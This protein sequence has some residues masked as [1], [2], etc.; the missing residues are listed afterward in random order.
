[1]GDDEIPVY[2]SH[3]VARLMNQDDEMVD[4]CVCQ[5]WQLD[6]GRIEAGKVPADLPDKMD[7]CPHRYYG[8]PVMKPVYNALED[9][10]RGLEP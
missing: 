8:K 6:T 7:E 9:L 10:E 5:V 3:L 2:Q 1:M 4:A